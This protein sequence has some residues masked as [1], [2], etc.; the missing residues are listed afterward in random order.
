MEKSD[1]TKFIS[2]DLNKTTIDRHFVSGFKELRK[3]DDF[4]DEQSADE[5]YMW[6][7]NVIK[8]NAK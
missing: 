6:L 8:S 7:V 1:L 4:L 5:V 2:A 3:G